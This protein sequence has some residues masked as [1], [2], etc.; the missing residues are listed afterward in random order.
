[1]GMAVPH[2]KPASGVAPRHAHCRCII[3]RS[4]SGGRLLP[5]FWWC[6]DPM[7]LKLRAVN[8]YISEFLTGVCEERT[9]ERRGWRGRGR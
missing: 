6:A 3:V 7:P 8:S 2:R 5:P 1:M 4:S 9:A